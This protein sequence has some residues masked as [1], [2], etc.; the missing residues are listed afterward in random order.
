MGDFRPIACCNVIYN[1]ITMILANH[2][3]PCLGDLVSLTLSAF[4][5]S[6]S[7]TENILVAQEI[8]RN[9]RKKEG[10]PKTHS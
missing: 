7:I 3:L 9:C 6:R 1:R 5:P 10:Q 4:V 2:L 8:A